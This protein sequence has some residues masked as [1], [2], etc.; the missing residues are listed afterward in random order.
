MFPGGTEQNSWSAYMSQ[1]N[2]HQLFELPY[3]QQNQ[4]GKIH[5]V[6]KGQISLM[7]FV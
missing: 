6:Y 3:Q 5:I 2:M 1:M 7:D 4:N